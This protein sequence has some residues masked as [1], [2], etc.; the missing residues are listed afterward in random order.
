ML[1]L[2]L[3]GV[4]VQCPLI[5]KTNVKKKKKKPIIE[6]SINSHCSCRNTEALFQYLNILTSIFNASSYHYALPHKWF[7]LVTQCQ[8]VSNLIHPRWILLQVEMKCIS[9]TL[10][11]SHTLHHFILNTSL[12][13]C[14]CTHTSLLTGQSL[15]IH[16]RF[17]WLHTL[18]VTQLHVCCSA[19]ADAINLTECKHRILWWTHRSNDR[20]F[21]HWKSHRGITFLSLYRKAGPIRTITSQLHLNV[22]S[23]QCY[24][25]KYKNT[26]TSRGLEITTQFIFFSESKWKK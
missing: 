14:H 7:Q 24:T 19:I 11:D 3:F 8:F 10:T 2:E 17:G 1:I 12:H 9:Q 21:Q 18:M 4:G 26:K 5:I 22:I 15:A 16:F 20:S 13:L 23:N 25:L 6:Q